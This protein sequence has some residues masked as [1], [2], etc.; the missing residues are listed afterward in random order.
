MGNKWMKQLRQYEDSVDYE[1]DSFAPENCLYTPSPYF[2]WIFANKSMGIPKNS[3][4]LWY[5]KPKAGKSLSLYAKVLDM[6]RRDKAAGLK[7][8]DRRHAI[9]FNTEIR[10]QLQHG[11]FPEI[12]LDYLTIYDTNDPVE[13]FDRVEKD[14]KPMVQDGMPLAYLGIDSL[15][16][17][18]GVKRG[19]ADS[20]ADHLVGD[21]ALTV[22]I[23]LMKLV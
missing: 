23:G 4:V 6:Q 22:S 1:Y 16:N 14:I 9:I 3:S 18:M 8:D 21:H 17:V 12:D 2:N 11:V 13:I 7:P 10:G 19:D 5:S 20:V 15:T